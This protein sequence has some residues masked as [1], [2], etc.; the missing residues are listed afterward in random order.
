MKSQPNLVESKLVETKL[1]ESPEARKMRRP[2]RHKIRSLAHLTLDAANGAILRD[3]NEF[4]IALQTVTPLALEQQVQLRFE[5]ASP[6]LRVEGAGRIAW[7]DS[8]G[9]AGVEFVDLPERSER[10][11]KEWIFVQILSAAYLFAP[12]E[13]AAVEGNRAEGAA[14]LLFSAA[15]RPAIPLEP[16]PRA[17]LDGTDRSGSE[18]R[19]PRY[20][21]LCC[22]I[23]ISLNALSKL[24]DG[25]ILLCAVLLF[26]VMAML[27]TDLLPTWLITIPLA[28]A[29]A[30]VF[31]TLYWFVFA[32]WFG[33]TP[34][35]RL[36]RMACLE[37][38]G[39]FE[40]EDQ[41]RFR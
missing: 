12:S 39:M 6:K 11:L 30:G 33:V 22:P 38:G 34:G 41:A 14:E 29:V 19:P 2:Y 32:R 27:L 20:R 7:T 37:S 10:L 23:P 8:W 9:Q 28:L 17:V 18:Q 3:L 24:L 36:A 21:L 1:A 26:A 15:P 4:G 35:E 25:L 31:G 16:Q 5:L 40:E 13:T